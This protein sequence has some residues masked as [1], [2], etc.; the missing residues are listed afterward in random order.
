M[1]CEAPPKTMANQWCV[2][3]IESSDQRYYTGISTDINRRWQQH[4]TGKQGAKFFNGRKPVRLLYLEPG[5]NR[6]TAS[7]REAEIKKLS[8]SEK[9]A[10]IRTVIKPPQQP[11]K[12]AAGQPNSQ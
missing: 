3:I 2:Y 5:H 11:D 6:S 4:L 7:K 10:L 1:S 8:R 12:A 9:E